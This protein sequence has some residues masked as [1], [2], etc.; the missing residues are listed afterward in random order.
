MTLLEALIALLLGVVVVS[1]AGRTLLH[2]TDVA[3]E[4]VSR[5]DRLVARRVARLTLRS[6]LSA[7][8]PGDVRSDGGDSLRIRAIRGAG[9]ICVIESNAVVVDLT[10][11]RATDP[12]KD[13][14]ELV[15]PLGSLRTV[16]VI[17]ATWAPGECGPTPL[18]R[19]ARLESTGLIDTDLIFARVFETG[20]YHLSRGALRYRRG[21][22]GRQPLTP[23][24]W[25]RGSALSLEEGWVRVSI[26][27]ASRDSSTISLLVR[28]W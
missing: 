4:A 11:S 6:E 8:A 12:E 7:L 20:A 24:V 9:R 28:S 1:L 21:R 10:G 13:S 23:Q 25:S 27:E 14:L 17:S 5:D 18:G 19:P 22:G 2:V 3:R 16:D 26:H 15:G